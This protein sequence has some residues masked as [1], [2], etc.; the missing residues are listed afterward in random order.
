MPLIS[1]QAFACAV[2]M[3]SETPAAAILWVAVGSAHHLKQNDIAACLAWKA[4]LAVSFREWMREQ[5]F[6]GPHAAVLVRRVA[7]P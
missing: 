7:R 2:I 4:N 1:R 3:T 6:R 5:R